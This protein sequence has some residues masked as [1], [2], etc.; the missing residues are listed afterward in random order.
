MKIALPAT[1]L[2]VFLVL[3]PPSEDTPLRSTSRATSKVTLS[4]LASE[5]LYNSLDVPTRSA[6]LGSTKIFRTSDGKVEIYCFEK[7]RVPHS[8]TIT[9]DDTGN[10]SKNLVIED[11]DRV[12]A[13]VHRV[14]DAKA[15]YKAFR[16]E[17]SRGQSEDRKVYSTLDGAAEIRCTR[18]KYKFRAP[19]RCA[20][21]LWQS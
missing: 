10:R 15:L 8:C 2:G 16:T 21:S 20:F 18:G 19:Y 13:R 14:S 5:A 17:V 7:S 12:V 9:F 4:A 3:A 11:E 6:G 1:T